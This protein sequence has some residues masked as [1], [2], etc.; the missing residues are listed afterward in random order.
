M[1]H[2]LGLLWWGMVFG[3]AL[4]RSGAS[5]Y[6]LIYGMFSGEDLSLAYLMA[7]A[8]LIAAL[9]MRLLRQMGNRTA[10]GAPTWF[11]ARRNPALTVNIRSAGETYTIFDATTGEAIGTVDGMRAFKECGGPSP[12]G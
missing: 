2:K 9:G 10:D 6:D 11:P 5:E 7:T 4:S 8:I 3:F 12:A 1:R